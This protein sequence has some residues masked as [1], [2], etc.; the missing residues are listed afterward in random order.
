MPRLDYKTCRECG[1]LADEAGVMSHTRLCPDCSKRLK[2]EVV[3]QLHEHR[4]P[5]FEHWRVRIAAS[6]GATIPERNL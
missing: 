5:W 4:G 6:V 3:T 2:I 1:R